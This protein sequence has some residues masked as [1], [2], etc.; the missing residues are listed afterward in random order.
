MALRVFL[1]D[2]WWPAYV[3][4]CPWIFWWGAQ[5]AS[6]AVEF[7]YYLQALAL[8]VFLAG[9]L[10][11]ELLSRPD[12]RLRDT[13]HLPRHFS[14]HPAVTLALAF[15]VWAV[16]AAGFAPSPIVAFLGS[17]YG[18]GDGAA[19]AM[20][21]SLA[22]VLVYVQGLRDSRL[23]SRI[24]S[25][26]L[27]SGFSLAVLAILEVLR[28]QALQP[29]ALSVPMGSFNGPGHLAGMLTLVAAVAVAW[30]YQNNRLALVTALVLAVAIGLASKRAVLIGLLLALGAGWRTPFRLLLAA[31]VVALGL[32]TGFQGAASQQ[33]LARDLGDPTTFSTRA[34][35]WEA[36]LAGVLA[37]PITGWGAGQFDEVWPR[38]LNR[39]DV[40][41]YLRL[42]FGIQ[43]VLHTSYTP[44]GPPAF[45][46]RNASGEVVSFFVT[47]WK[48]HNQLLEV[49]LLRGLAGLALYLLL[50]SM[51]VRPAWL[52]N[53]AAVGILAYLGFTMLWFVPTQ[54]E[55][56]M[57][58]LWAVALLPPAATKPRLQPAK[59][60][61]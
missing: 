59:P 9:G 18:S 32:W 17:L 21:L 52:G 31:V 35:L 5:S 25:M 45:L 44:F 47:P 61:G 53:P 49:G 10:I 38:Y 20:G 2:W 48:S 4:V 14:R 37:R 36:A 24:L 34:E 23:A 16:I 11:F 58:V 28:N 29:H 42:E 39:Q 56:V 55:G 41:T 46:V 27:V 26:L 54:V 8:A 51:L 60:G 57:W 19:W 12:L 15:G 30:W 33:A 50:I 1:H 43:E 3:L 13:I 22:F 7:T 40:E 6:E